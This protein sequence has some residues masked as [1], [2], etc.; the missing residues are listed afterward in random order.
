MIVPVTCA[1]KN[2]QFGN[3]MYS[4]ECNI[5]GSGRRRNLDCATA[6]WGKGT[7]VSHVLGAESVELTDGRTDPIGYFMKRKYLLG[8]WR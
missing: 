6:A 3:V 1:T 5:K 2:T 8:P 4:K 7:L